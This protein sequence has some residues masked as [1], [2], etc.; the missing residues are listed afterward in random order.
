MHFSFGNIQI[1]KD[2]EV[3]FGEHVISQDKFKYL[4]SII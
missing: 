1:R 4:G 2:I 3:K